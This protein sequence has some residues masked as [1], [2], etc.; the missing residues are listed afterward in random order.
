MG[1]RVHVP[2]LRGTLISDMPSIKELLP[3]LWSP[4]TQIFGRAM[5][6]SSIPRW[7]NCW[8]R[9]TKVFMSKVKQSS[10]EDTLLVIPGGCC[11]GISVGPLG[12]SF[13]IR[14]GDR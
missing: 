10:V 13:S 14:V 7:L 3:V 2:A 8:I 9:L 1:Q 12:V 5:L 4:T 6:L 11:V